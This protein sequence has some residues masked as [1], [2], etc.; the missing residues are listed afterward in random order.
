MILKNKFNFLNLEDASRNNLEP[1]SRWLVSP[2]LFFVD[3]E[4]IEWYRWPVL[5]TA[6]SLLGIQAQRS[7]GEKDGRQNQWATEW[8]CDPFKIPF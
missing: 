7:W 3:L 4:S 5:K 8:V 2:G 6:D 1:L